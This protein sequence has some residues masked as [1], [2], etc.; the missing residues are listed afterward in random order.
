MPGLA[1]AAVTVLTIVLIGGV[2]ATTTSLGCGGADRLNLSLPRCEAVNTAVRLQ[3]SPSAPGAKGHPFPPAVPPAT[4]PYPPNQ[5]PGSSYPPNDYPGSSYPP[6]N[7]PGSSYPP[8]SNSAS[9]YPPQDPFIGTASPG[10]PPALSLNCR[11][12]IFA[13][14]PGSGGFIQ[15]PQGN[16]TAD[17]RSAVALPSPSPG[18]SPPPGPGGPGP[19]YGYGMAYDMAHSRWLPVRQEWVAPD[20]LHYAYP[21]NTSIYLVDTS[22]NTQV[23]VASGHAWNLLRVLDDRLFATIPNAPGLWMVPF[24]GSAKQI[25]AVGYWQAA[26]A[27]AAFGTQTS[28]V[29]QGAQQNLIKVDV[30]TGATSDWFAMDGASANVL[31]IDS[32]GNPIVQGYFRDGQWVVWLTTGTSN[33]IVIANSG[34]N[35]Y[36]QGGALGD[37]HGVW[38][39][40]SFQY[41]GSQGMVLYVQGSGLYWMGGV[42]G[43]PAGPCI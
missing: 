15:F 10:Y 30:S 13:G 18:T 27:T 37:V 20:G 21:Y 2:L 34:E 29:P 17:P 36:L 40:A 33:P 6:N 22:N 32:H 42:A 41:S 9:A 31:A 38:F 23:E 28:A 3:A 39:P 7:Y 5:N 8:N 1:V 24:S 26:S 16:F 14:P 19:G 4:A 11:L 43:Q 12:P 35:L 25:T